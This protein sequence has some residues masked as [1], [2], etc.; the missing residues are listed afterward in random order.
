MDG[1]VAG[2]GYMRDA[3][4]HDAETPSSPSRGKESHGPWLLIYLSE[5]NFGRGQKMVVFWLK[6]V[7]VSIIRPINGT[8]MNRKAQVTYS[9]LPLVLTNGLQRKQL[10]ALAK[11]GLSGKN[12]IPM[13][14]I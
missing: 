6:P 10:Q 12:V 11:P 9:S 3:S 1:V 4:L 13:R 7:N 2:R 14:Q 8:A 5:A